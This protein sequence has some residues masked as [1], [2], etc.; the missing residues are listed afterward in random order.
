MAKLLEET[1]R[2][3]LAVLKK[4]P[5]N[6]KEKF[7]T[8]WLSISKAMP[9]FEIF[10]SPETLV[11]LKDCIQAGIDENRAK[12]IYIFIAG[13]I[14]VDPADELANLS[15]RFNFMETIET[16][17]EQIKNL[18]LAIKTGNL[19]KVQSLIEHGVDV[20]SKNDYGYSALSWAIGW[21]ELKIAKLLLDNGADVNYILPDT[22]HRNYV[23]MSLLMSIIE[24]HQ[25]L[26]KSVDAV[27][28]LLDAGADVNAKDQNNKTVLDYAIHWKGNEIINMI[29]AALENEAKQSVKETPP[30]QMDEQQPRE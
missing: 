14:G 9:M 3:R 8:I 18:F 24:N 5:M 26:P 16:P 4:T 11:V 23:G 28:L 7:T 13:K 25:A 20:N 12:Q 10:H 1:V 19:Q 27:R 30:N 2:E 15:K 22:E 6:E 17:A 29:Q 21:R